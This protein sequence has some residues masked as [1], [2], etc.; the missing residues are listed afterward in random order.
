MVQWWWI[1]ASFGIVIV[2]VALIFFL[3]NLKSFFRYLKISSM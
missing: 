1:P 3:L 2:G